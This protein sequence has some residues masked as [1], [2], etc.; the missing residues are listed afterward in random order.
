MVLSFCLEWGGI[1]SGLW[2]AQI[3]FVFP[4]LST[5]DQIAER[6]AAGRPSSPPVPWSAGAFGWMRAKGCAWVTA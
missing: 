6:G 3:P 2:E 5:L 4:L 1:P